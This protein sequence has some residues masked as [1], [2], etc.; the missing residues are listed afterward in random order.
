MN[1]PLLFLFVA[2]LISLQ[3][4]SQSLSWF[5]G[6]F[7]PGTYDTRSTSIRH[8]NLTEA[9]YNC[10]MYLE[11]TWVGYSMQTGPILSYIAKYDSSGNTIWIRTITSNV[12]TI[13]GAFTTT[14]LAVD[15]A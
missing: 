4:G 2:L 5:K 11:K 14:S 9:T 6:R 10:G 13:G 12:T 3:G 15:K 8:S 1:K 7:V